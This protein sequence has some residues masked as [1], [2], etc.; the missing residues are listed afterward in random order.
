MRKLFLLFA[1]LTIF[2][3]NANAQQPT[4]E[5]AKQAIG[6][7]EVSC[8]AS[9]DSG[10]V[11]LA[12]TFESTLTFDSYSV[13][14]TP[15]NGN[16]SVFLA[17]YNSSGNVV[18]V[19]S[20]NDS[21]SSANSPSGIAIDASGNVYITGM[22]ISSTITFGAFTLINHSNNAD[23]YFVKYDAGGNVIWAKGIGGNGYEC[24][25]GLAIDALGNIYVTG[26]YNSFALSFG[27]YTIFNSSSGGICNI[28]LAKYDSS[29]NALWAK[30]AG[31][32][33]DDE[34]NW[35]ACDL[36]G[37][38][39]ITGFFNSQVAHFGLD[40]IINSSGTADFFLAKYDTSGNVKWVKNAKGQCTDVGNF[41][42]TD[43]HGNVYVTGYY[44]S[45]AIFIDSD[46]L[47]YNGV[48]GDNVFIVKYDSSGQ[49]QWA[50]RGIGNG[51]G[52]SLTIDSSES[53]YVCGGMEDSTI[54]FNNI[55]LNWTGPYVICHGPEPMFIVKFNSIGNAIYGFALGAGGDDFCGIFNGPSNSIYIGGDFM[56]HL[57]IIG[58][59]SLTLIS[60]ES[61][62]IA[63]FG[64]S[65]LG[66]PEIKSEQNIILYPNP[67]SGTFTLSIR[68][69]ELGIRNG[70]IKIYDVL[71][72]EVYS[73][74]I[75]NQQSSIINLPDLSNGIYY[76]EMMGDK[77][78]EGKGKIA[79]MH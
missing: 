7:G 38:V 78:I 34:A 54:S 69:Y 24:G 19:K 44:E 1:I 51:I 49:L 18:W 26:I 48:G 14:T 33:N 72:N 76:W 61:P 40:S 53:V 3:L 13:I 9:D 75:I 17:K 8:M 52:Y 58:N 74:A 63:K 29:G 59:D 35:V 37:N 46:T 15:P 50:N 6:F 36:F 77:G 42:K 11:Y 25:Q 28:F 10:N 67:T 79:I 70:K 2:V 41:V 66:I 43:S 55:N 16:E 30:S 4:W 32:L 56:P 45:G 22:F 73:Q 68:N 64:T 21:A 31:G 62:F 39:Y 60:G 57:F 27:N 71:G 12:G 65:D 47:L 23:M 20:P 5:W